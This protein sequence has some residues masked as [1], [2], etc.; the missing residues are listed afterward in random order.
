MDK[1]E[2]L[3][4]ERIEAFNNAFS[5]GAPIEIEGETHIIISHEVEPAYRTVEY[6]YKTDKGLEFRE[7]QMFDWEPK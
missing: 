5:D 7:I 4:R 1:A 6:K 3:S 2:Q